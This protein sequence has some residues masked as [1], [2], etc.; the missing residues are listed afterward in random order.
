MV[1]PE[2]WARMFFQDRGYFGPRINGRDLSSEEFHVLVCHSLGLHLI[3]ENFF[4]KCQLLVLIG[5][6]HDFHGETEAEGKFT[7]KHVRKMLIEVDDKP[8]DL[9]EKF[10]RTCGVSLPVPLEEHINKRLLLDDLTL[11]DNNIFDL[12]KIDHIPHVLVLHG[13]KDKTV[14]VQRSRHIAAQV[15]HASLVEIENGGHGLPFS[16]PDL[17]WDL[18]GQSVIK[19]F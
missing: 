4:P 11:L 15:R 16:H 19:I 12:K 1:R 10:R 2:N 5:C 8:R 7:R 13:D 18:I 17:C 6:F 14:P 3:D 9:L